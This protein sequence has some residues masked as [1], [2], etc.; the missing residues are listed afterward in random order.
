M[1]EEKQCLRCGRSGHRA[2]Q[3]KVDLAQPCKGPWARY[4]DKAA[5]A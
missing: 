1:T 3:C 4:A 5:E 2:S